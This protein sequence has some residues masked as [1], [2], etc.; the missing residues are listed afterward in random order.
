M[1][2]EEYE[3]RTLQ[4]LWD[5][6]RAVVNVAGDLAMLDSHELYVVQSVLANI[7]YTGYVRAGG[8]AT[9][10]DYREHIDAA[11]KYQNTTA[12]LNTAP[13][14]GQALEAPGRS[15]APNPDVYE[16]IVIPK[17]ENE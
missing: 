3:K 4:A 5:Q 14:M 10:Y 6:Y 16:T 11:A 1:T 9:K 2:L 13:L 12:F 15:A 7:L 8:V 17:V